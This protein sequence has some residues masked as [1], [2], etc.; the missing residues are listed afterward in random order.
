[1]KRSIPA[2]LWRDTFTV[3]RTEYL[4]VL[5]PECVDLVRITGVLHWEIVLSEPVVTRDPQAVARAVDIIVSKECYYGQPLGVLLDYQAGFF[6]VRRFSGNSPAD[7]F[8][9]LRAIHSDAF[10]SGYVIIG[11]R[12][13]HHAPVAVDSK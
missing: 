3:R 12:A 11:A 13:P 6:Y 8:V 1:M 10:T 9:K 7:V 4:L 2:Q 5:W